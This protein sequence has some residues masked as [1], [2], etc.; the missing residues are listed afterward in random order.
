MGDENGAEAEKCDPEDAVRGLRIE[1]KR[2][3]LSA[4]VNV[5]ERV[6][7]AEREEHHRSG[8][9]GTGNDCAPMAATQDTPRRI[10]AHMPVSMMNDTVLN[11]MHAPRRPPIN[12]NSAAWPMSR[13]W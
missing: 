2:Q 7:E 13:A 4:G 9:D 1:T 8:G 10:G 5:S 12:R 3:E 6:G 11:S